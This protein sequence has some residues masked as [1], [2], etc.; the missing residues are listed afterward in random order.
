MTTTEGSERCDI[1]GFEN[2]GR[3]LQTKKC[4][5]PLESGKGNEKDFLLES[6]NDLILA[7]HFRSI[8]LL[9][10]TAVR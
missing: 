5:K 3:E 1:A 2:G 9:T 6:A 7:L 4:E 8:G 10:Y